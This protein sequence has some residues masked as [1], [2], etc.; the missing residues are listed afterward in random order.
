MTERPVDGLPLEGSTEVQQTST[1]GQVVENTDGYVPLSGPLSGNAVTDAPSPVGGVGAEPVRTAPEPSLRCKC[2]ALPH[3]T[4]ADICQK[5]HGLPGNQ[6]GRVHPLESLDAVPEGAS[7][8]PLSLAQ[9][10]L[11][12]LQEE[13]RRLRRHLRLHLKPSERRAYRKDLRQMSAEALQ[14]CQ[15]LESVQPAHRRAEDAMSILSRLSEETLAAA[16]KDCGVER[17]EDVS[18]YDGP[19]PLRVTLTDEPHIPTECPCQHALISGPPSS[20]EPDAR[21]RRFL[22]AEPPVFERQ[23]SRPMLAVSNDRLKEPAIVTE[24]RAQLDA[25]WGTKGGEFRV[26]SSEEDEQPSGP[27][28]SG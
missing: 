2:G 17:L 10:T 11:R 22:D 16:L 1:P 20:S 28:C 6:L 25:A 14:V 19:L 12:L 26:T 5:G 15:F 13:A 9:E 3:P 21:T 24:A 18:G 7:V 27:L 8:D 4:R 23:G